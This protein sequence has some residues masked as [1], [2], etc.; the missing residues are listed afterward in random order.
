MFVSA[1]FAIILPF[2]TFLFAYAVLGPL[3]Y[4]TEINWLQSRNYFL[5]QMNHVSFR[6]LV[7]IIGA[8]LLINSVL[9]IDFYTNYLA[10]FYSK[11]WYIELKKWLNYLNNFYL[12]FALTSAVGWIFF[13]KLLHKLLWIV[14]TTLVDFIALYAG[15]GGFITWFT[16]FL[17][18]IIHVWLFTGIFV[19]AGAIKS[20]NPSGW[21]SLVVF[22]LISIG[23]F[24]VHH[25]VNTYKI[26]TYTRESFIKTN[27]NMVNTSVFDAFFR[28]YAG[29]NFMLNSQIGLRIQSLIAFAYT[30]HYLNWFSKTSIIKW[31]QVPKLQL[32]AILVFWLFCLALY[33][34]N[35]TLGL[36]TLY[37]LSVMHVI[38]EFP[39]NSLVIKQM[40]TWEK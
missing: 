4:L 5:A 19:I 24:F 7:I 2:E 12:Y 3:H 36:A 17:P 29:Q 11:S 33:L 27:F 8:S 18:T 28:N 35:Y 23:L 37:F 39:L 22:V 9:A 26:S 20:K 38:M 34:Y 32:G 13:E 1:W 30:Y 21:F 31:H 6:I 16:I 10:N 25:D 15:F 14:I 40:F